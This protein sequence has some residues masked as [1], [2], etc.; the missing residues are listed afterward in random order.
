MTDDIEAAVEVHQRELIESAATL[1]AVQKIYGDK[2][3]E[4]SKTAYRRLVD[5]HLLITGVLASGLLRISGKITPITDT[6]E[7]RD[8][9]FASYIIGMEPCERAIEE[10]RYLQ[11][12]ALLRQEMETLAQLKAVTAGK[13]NENRSPNV[14]VL[15]ESIARLYGELSA[16]AHV[17]KHHMV[18][19]VT[20]WD[21]SGEN[22]PGPT[23]GTRY[24]P[25]FVEELARRS[26]SLHLV[27]PLRLI[28]EMS[29]NLHERY[30]D[31]GFTEREAEA[32]NLAVQ[33]M[34]TEGML[35]QNN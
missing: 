12:H 13:R 35:E 18:R 16:A 31:D 28:E 11:A 34:I 1:Y 22:L 19:A 21:V 2:V 33:L 9:L 5:A 7:E 26:F 25:A 20:E 29:I 10:G 6:S 14:A 3:R 8:A 27:L 32:V 15:E 17:S 24:F 23:S 30:G 4:Q